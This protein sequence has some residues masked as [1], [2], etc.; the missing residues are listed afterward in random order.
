MPPNGDAKGMDPSRYPAAWDLVARTLTA[1][2]VGSTSSCEVWR[3]MIIA[4]FSHQRGNLHREVLA[5]IHDVHCWLN[6][7]FSQFRGVKDLDISSPKP[8]FFETASKTLLVRIHTNSRWVHSRKPSLLLKVQNSRLSQHLWYLNI[9]KKYIMHFA[10]YTCHR[11][12]LHGNG[13][14]LSISHWAWKPFLA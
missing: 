9:F 10:V 7:G 2:R 12:H 11:V 5:L 4:M 3:Q 14:A 8:E 13:E 1:G 6:G